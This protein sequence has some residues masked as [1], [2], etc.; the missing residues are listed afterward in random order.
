MGAHRP[1]SLSRRKKRGKKMEDVLKK[2]RKPWNKLEPPST[3]SRSEGIWVEAT[4]SRVVR[5]RC[6]QNK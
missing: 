6:E 2:K 4:S 5:Y 1:P 3:V